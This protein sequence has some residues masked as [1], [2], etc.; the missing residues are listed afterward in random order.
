MI[1]QLTS[2]QY[3]GGYVVRVR[4]ADGVE[5]DV[6]LQAEL[7]GEVFEPLKDLELF[8]GLRLDPE[9]NSITWPCGADFAPEFLYE[10][11]AQHAAAADA[12]SRRG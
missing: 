5:G 3:V 6:D 7:Y 8:R 11:A 2:A 1:P 10:H 4:F 12:A 9:L